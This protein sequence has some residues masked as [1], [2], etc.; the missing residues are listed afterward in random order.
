MRPGQNDFFPQKE[1]RKFGLSAGLVWEFSPQA[2][3]C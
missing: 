3:T 1:T 2:S